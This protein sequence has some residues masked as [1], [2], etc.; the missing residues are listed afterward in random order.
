MPIRNIPA[1]CAAMASLLAVLFVNAAPTYGQYDGENDY[2]YRFSSVEEYGAESVQ[3]PKDA[4]DAELEELTEAED[5]TVWEETD[6]GVIGLLGR[7]RPPQN[8]HMPIS[9]LKI[10]EPLR[11]A[12]GRIPTELMGEG[13]ITDRLYTIDN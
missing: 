11:T 5:E 13:Q 8:R 4:Q 3:E 12:A 2:S 9:V 6:T 7:L 10:P 1:A